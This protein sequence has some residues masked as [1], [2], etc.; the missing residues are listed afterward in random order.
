[1]SGEHRTG[2]KLHVEFNRLL[3]AEVLVRSQVSPLKIWVGRIDI[4]TGL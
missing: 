4:G 3:T 2:N 1:L